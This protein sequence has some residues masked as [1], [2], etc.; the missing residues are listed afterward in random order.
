MQVAY[1]LVLLLLQTELDLPSIDGDGLLGHHDGRQRLGVG[2]GLRGL[3]RHVVMGC[4]LRDLL[5]VY[6]Y[7]G[8]GDLVLLWSRKGF[9]E[10]F[11]YIRGLRGRFWLNRLRFG[12][13]GWLYYLLMWW[14]R[15]R[16]GRQWFLLYD[17]FLY[18]IIDEDGL[19]GQFSDPLFGQVG[20]ID[21]HIVRVLFGL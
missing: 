7:L 5:L 21:D 13:W 11:D 15:W 2:L 20:S 8:D 12:R 1:P 3:R 10:L 19:F 17:D 6:G 9:E 18:L 16:W 14:R 4:V